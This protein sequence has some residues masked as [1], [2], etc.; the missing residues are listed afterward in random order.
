MVG[1]LL[2][3]HGDVTSGT[4]M[5][6]AKLMGGMASASEGEA[7]DLSWSRSQR[8]WVWWKLDVR[9]T[10]LVLVLVLSLSSC[11]E[12]ALISKLLPPGLY[13]SMPLSLLLKSL[14]LPEPEWLL[15]SRIQLWLLLL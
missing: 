10:L 12:P 4:G 6:C 2:V 3:G 9:D 1:G 11:V 7:V 13:T 15:R 14:G 5:T 8:W